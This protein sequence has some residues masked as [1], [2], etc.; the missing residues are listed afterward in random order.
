[1]KEHEF[2]PIPDIK[3]CIVVSAIKNQDQWGY[4]T[5]TINFADGMVLLVKEEGQV[6]HFSCK[7]EWRGRK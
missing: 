3:N 2:G 5:L 1:M 7:T 6:G 4:D